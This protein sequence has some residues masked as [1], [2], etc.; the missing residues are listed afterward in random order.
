MTSINSNKSC[1]RCVVSKLG[2]G[3]A[4]IGIET[5]G[6]LVAGSILP[7][8]NSFEAP[9]IKSCCTCGGIVICSNLGSSDYDPKQPTEDCKYCI[10][11]NPERKSTNS[12]FKD[13]IDPIDKTESMETL[14]TWI[15]NHSE[16]F[17]T[18]S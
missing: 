4:K 10:I 8:S 1:D 5:Y 9:H 15:K 17:R 7:F 16:L 12:Y 14:K 3:R 18:K 6:R 13:T 2:K 11:C